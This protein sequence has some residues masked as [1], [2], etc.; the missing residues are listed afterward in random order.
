MIQVIIETPKGIPGLKKATFI[1]GGKYGRGFVSCRNGNNERFGPPASVRFEGGK[2]SNVRIAN[3]DG[4][5]GVEILD[6]G[7]RTSAP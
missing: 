4:Q 5:I 6:R 3:Y 1:V 7:Q 2:T